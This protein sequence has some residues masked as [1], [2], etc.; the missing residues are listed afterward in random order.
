MT[1]PHPA[2][3]YTDVKKELNLD[4]AA[5]EKLLGANERW[6]RSSS[7]DGW[8]MSH[9]AIRLDLRDMKAAV[10]S[11]KKQAATNG[12][13]RWQVSG[14][15]EMVREF[16]RQVTNHHNQEA[17]AVALE[18]APPPTTSERNG[19]PGPTVPA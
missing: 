4:D 12:L 3:L 8:V 17:R 16:N 11:L 13:Q 15:Q 14:L 18:A 2:N 19:L 5:L 10:E 9:E 1:L 6:P 7:E